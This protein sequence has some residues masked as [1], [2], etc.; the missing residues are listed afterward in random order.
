MRKRVEIALAELVLSGEGK[1]P[2][3]FRI[4]AAGVNQTRKGPVLFD[5]AAVAAVLADFE[6]GGV[7]LPIDYEHA[8]A[9]GPAVPLAE[10]A[11]AGWFKP[12][13]RDGELWA[14]EVDWTARGRASVEAKEF[15]YTSLWGDLERVKV[16]GKD[17]MRLV[18][19]FNVGLVNRPAT[20]GTLPLVASEGIATEI[21]NMGDTTKENGRSPFVVTLGARDESEALEKVAKMRATLSD[22]AGVLGAPE[23]DLGAAVRALKLSADAA[24][25]LKT[26]LA[27]LK[28][29]AETAERDGLIARLS[30]EG[31][32]PPALHEWARTQPIKSLEV[33]GAHAPALTSDKA[34]PAGPST[35]VV[36]LS[37]E[38]KKAL[39]AQGMSPEEY[40]KTKADMKAAGVEG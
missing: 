7:D 20:I 30:E 23:E 2:S 19:L 9:Y 24:A 17:V 1:A 29:K 39:A 12:E 5:A 10:R 34:P 33:F 38:L 37:E 4:L 22:V 15:R 40:V 3:E 11:A 31:K 16:D 25:A 13:E 26:E 35:E 27:E 8:M 28:S 32:L 6:G 18:R 36:V 14:T 21:D